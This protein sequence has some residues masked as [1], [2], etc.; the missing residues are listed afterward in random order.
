MKAFQERNPFA[1]GVVGVVLVSLIGFVG[2]NYDRLP[3]ISPTQTYS[4]YF[5]EAGGLGDGAA[6]QVSGLE[7]GRVEGIELDGARVLIRFKVADDVRLGDRS[8]VAIKT[9]SLLGS[10]ILEVTP[11]GE[12]RQVG[13]I[14]IERTTAPYQL[15]DALGDITAQISGLDTGQLSDAFRTL[16]A[17]FADT[18]PD[19]AVAVDGV[20]RFADVLNTRD[21]QLRSLL[22]NANKATTV[23]GERSHQIAELISDTNALLVQLQT[24]SAALDQLSRNIS[25][26]SQQIVGFISDN[27]STLKPALDKLNGVLAIVQNRKA[28]VQRSIKGLGTYVFSLGESVSSGPFFKAY[29]VNLL[30]GQFVQPFIDA[31]FSDLG[32]DPTVVLPSERMDPQTGQ[33]G[34]PGLPVPYPR[35]GQ[36]G[37]PHLTLPGAITG[38]PGDTRYPYRQPL[39]QP[40]PGG[41]PPGPPAGYEPTPVPPAP[42]LSG[43]AA[44]GP[45]NVTVVPMPEDT[46]APTPPP[47]PAP[48]SA[49]EVGTP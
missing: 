24:Q 30:P 10:K 29:V 44:P 40:E 2:L 7:V 16:S 41:P 15:P 9:R 5:A 38:N 27:R 47:T 3:F 48:E 23:L 13:P 8:E 20:A 18:P 37:D 45:G 6:V 11:R 21:G 4:A 43:P 33:P 19:L 34:T 1:I 28:E 22:E 17:T 31:A 26:L 36:G 39:P 35:T 32:L 42:V 14:P 25:A 12:G 49:I 46:S